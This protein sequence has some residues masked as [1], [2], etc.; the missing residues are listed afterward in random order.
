VTVLVGRAPAGEPEAVLDGLQRAARRRAAAVLAGVQ[1]E[2]LVAI[3]GAADP[4][5]VATALAA[6]FGD[7]PVV[8]G[9]QVVDLSEAATSATAALAGLQAA[10]AWP[11]APRPVSAEELLP[12]RAIAGDPVARERLVEDIY[13]PLT[14]AGGHVLETVAAYLESGE[15]LEATARL[16][17]VHPNTVRY[18]LRRVAEVTG[19]N[20]TDP[21]DG[22]RLRIALALGRLA[23]DDNAL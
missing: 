4:P 20:P 10:P 23:R 7:G 18:R 3:V 22:F 2:R 11:G 1:G 9:P 5:A 21:R 16:L 12:E 15:S 13:S 8:L 17:F 19:A 6:E 14:G